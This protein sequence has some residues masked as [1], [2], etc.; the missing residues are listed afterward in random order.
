MSVRGGT[1]GTRT[2]MLTSHIQFL[3]W[4]VHRHRPN[5]IKTPRQG[6]HKKWTDFR[7]KEKIKAGNIKH[8]SASQMS[9][10]FE[11][12]LE[13]HNTPQY[14]MQTRVVYLMRREI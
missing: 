5:R 2:A 6:L 8:F 4:T 3:A 11:Y 7:L 12:T 13:Q 1:Y 9:V 10:S 14:V